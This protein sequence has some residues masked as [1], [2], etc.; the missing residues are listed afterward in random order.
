MTLAWWNICT[1]RK[2]RIWWSSCSTFYWC[3]RQN[4]AKLSFK[5]CYLL[6]FFLPARSSHHFHTF[7]DCVHR[8][9]VLIRLWIE[10]RKKNAPYAHFLDEWICASNDNAGATLKLIHMVQKKT[11]TRLWNALYGDAFEEYS[12]LIGKQSLI[13]NWDRRCSDDNNKNK[14]NNSKNKYNNSKKK[15]KINAMRQ[16]QHLNEN[17]QMESQR[18]TFTMATTKKHNSL[19]PFIWCCRE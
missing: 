10:W 3:T 17:L 1:H 5:I 18:V 19:K 13:T 15:T 6:F 7:D 12:P 16:K 4:A 8:R 9:R 11:A 14:N 2:G